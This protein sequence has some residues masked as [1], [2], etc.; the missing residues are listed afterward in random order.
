MKKSIWCISALALA[1][2]ALGHVAH[3]ESSPEKKELVAKMMQLQQ[4]VNELMARQLAEAPALRLTQQVGPAL[5]FRVA[6]EKR[7]ALAK[8]IQGDIKKYLDESV[9]LLRERA[10]KLAPTVVAPLFEE[11]FSEDELKQ[12]IA[13]LESPV[14]RKLA[15]VNQEIQKALTEKL[16]SDTRSAIEPKVK[17]MEQ[18]VSQRLN[19][20][21]AAPSSNVAAPPSKPASK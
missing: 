18:S 5:Q 1:L 13:F 19:Q 16:V 3:A 8:D 4:P 9:P 6:P 21:I 2:L 20:A 14:Q 12:L 10:T 7:E 11:R 15:G 17:T